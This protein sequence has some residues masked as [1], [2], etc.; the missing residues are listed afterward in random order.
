MPTRSVG[1]DK[2]K[3]VDLLCQALQ[4]ELSAVLV[5]EAAIRSAQASALRSH[6]VANLAGARDRASIL[7][8]ACVALGIAADQDTPGRAA[9]RRMQEAAVESMEDSRVDAPLDAAQLVAADC[10][11]AIEAQTEAAWRLIRIL[12]KALSGDRGKILRKACRQVDD[13]PGVAGGTHERA[14]ALWLQ[15]IGLPPERPARRSLRSP[16]SAQ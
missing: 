5:Y 10:V 4:C 2:A 7:G 12:A 8:D 16:L 3:V 11:V 13:G 15:A 14:H 6:W 9:V 1:A